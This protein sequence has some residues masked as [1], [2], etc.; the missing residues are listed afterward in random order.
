M[1][2][3]LYLFFILSV[4]CYSCTA[5]HV[6]NKPVFFIPDKDVFIDNDSIDIVLFY[7]SS[8]QLEAIQTE[9]V[10][11]KK[12]EVA[13]TEI[14]IHKPLF[15]QTSYSPI[16]VY[17]NEY[18]IVK[19]NKYNDVYFES[20]NNQKNNEILLFRDFLQVDSF[21]IAP[22]INTPTF[23]SLN[24][25][26]GEIK[27]F[28]ERNSIRSQKIFDSLQLKYNASKT[29]A[30]LTKD[31]LA[32]R[33]ELTL[34]LFYLDY[35]SFLKEHGLY[36]SKCSQ[37]LSSI[38]E[39]NNYSKFNNSAITVVNG[40]ANA[41]IDKPLY[42]ISNDSDFK[43]AFELINENFKNIPKDYLLSNLMYYA[44]IKKINIEKE[45]IGKYKKICTNKNYRKLI[46]SKMEEQE[47]INRGVEKISKNGNN[48]L[49][50]A[51][52]NQVCMFDDLLKTNKGK[53]I[54][55]DFW[56]TWCAPCIK[57][58]VETKQL[59]SNYSSNELALINIS[60]DKDYL[61][62]KDFILNNKLNLKNNYAFQNAS[63]NPFIKQYNI[64]TIPRYMLI[65]E[66]GKIIDDNA[67]RPS[68]PKL[69]ELI[70]KYLNAK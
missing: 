34:Y 46:L 12:G 41:L 60:F 29:F 2:K 15:I 20:N 65:D 25:I 40:V 55:I 16:I 47:R 11:L 70:D 58:M 61:A 14:K 19:S 33:N 6:F 56:A 7:E 18:I 4:A 62:W 13:K 49:I 54:L 21:F 31:F 10:L 51:T 1:I 68:D 63:V 48:I 28:N 30:K 45:Y 52:D 17:P 66:N 24:I 67:P 43:N 9:N 50:A 39:I 26:E 42:K 53:L 59:I 64:T 23:D 69:K 3:I 38:N 57:E 44:L 22:Q 5:L 27:K 35:K 32:N 36:K 37:L 8:K